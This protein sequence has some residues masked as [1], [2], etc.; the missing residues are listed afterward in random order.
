[1]PKYIPLPAK[2]PPSLTKP[3]PSPQRMQC[4]CNC[5]QKHGTTLYCSGERLA[6]LPKGIQQAQKAKSKGGGARESVASSNAMAMQ[7]CGNT[8]TTLHTTAARLRMN[9]LCMRENMTL[10]G[11]ERSPKTQ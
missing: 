8:G 9:H 5:S 3:N 2:G 10:G 7:G 4:Q 11:R 6:A 1:M